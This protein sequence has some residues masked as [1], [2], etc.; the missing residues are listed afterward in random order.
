MIGGCV[1]ASIGREAETMFQAQDVFKKL[2]WKRERLVLG[3]LIFEIDDSG[4]RYP[5]IFSI[6]VH[7]SSVTGMTESREM[8][9]S[10]NDANALSALTAASVT[11]VLSFFTGT[12]SMA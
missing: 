11:G 2:E 7:S 12:T 6:R 4:T 8:R 3:D 10:G 9:T 1:L 5:D